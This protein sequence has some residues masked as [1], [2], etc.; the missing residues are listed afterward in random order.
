MTSPDDAI[1]AA[2][3]ALDKTPPAAD[4]VC[5]YRSG[6]LDSMEL[7]QFLLEIE[8]ET[9]QRLDLPALVEGG[10]TLARVRAAL[11]AEPQDG[12]RDGTAQA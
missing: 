6:V 10:V 2:F 8:L 7:M 11:P 9:G 3:A 5:L 4:D 12:S 1:A